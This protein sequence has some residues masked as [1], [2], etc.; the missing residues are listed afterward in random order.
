MAYYTITDEELKTHDF[1][2]MDEV[3]LIDFLYERKINASKAEFDGDNWIDYEPEEPE[4]Y[5]GKPDAMD[6]AKER[7]L[8][9]GLDSYSQM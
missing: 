2:S 9:S 4:E 5:N 1:E 8:E 7:L 3:E 6:L